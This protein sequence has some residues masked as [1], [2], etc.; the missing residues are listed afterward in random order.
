[1]IELQPGTERRLVLTIG[2]V[3][4]PI[5]QRPISTIAD[6]GTIGFL[7]GLDDKGVHRRAV[8]VFK[9]G[10]WKGGRGG[11]ALK[12]KPL[13]WTVAGDSDAKPSGG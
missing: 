3:K 9:N 1:M 13:I 11:Q 6:E 2:T 7:D 8:G 10:E 5:I 4:M 12:F